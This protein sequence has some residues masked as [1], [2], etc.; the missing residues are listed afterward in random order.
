[1]NWRDRANV[2]RWGYGIQPPTV[3]THPQTK[4]TTRGGGGGLPRVKAS[5]RYASDVLAPTGPAW[6][7]EVVAPSL[8]K[9][10]VHTIATLFTVRK[11]TE[12]LVLGS[13]MYICRVIITIYGGGRAL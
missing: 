1:M 2:D 4:G 13:N 10:T 5:H 6:S 12:G 9:L 11:A 8:E 3:S 7:R